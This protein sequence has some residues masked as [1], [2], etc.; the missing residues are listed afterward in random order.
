MSQPKIG[1]SMLY[2]LSEPFSKMVKQLSSVPTK[3][4][5]V[6]DDGYHALSKKRVAVLNQAVKSHSLKYSVHAPFADINVASPSKTML[7]AS[8]K[9]L[10]L[11]MQYANDLDA[12]LWVFH[13]GYKS[14]IS[15]FYPGA[16][17]KQN[18]TSIQ[19]LDKTATDYGIKIAMENLPEKYNFLMK[20]P[21]DFTKFYTETGLTDI[22]IV[23]DTGHAYLEAQIQPFLQQ[24]PTKIAHVHISDNHGETD[25][26]LGLGSGSINWQQFTKELKTTG[27]SGTVLT[28]SVFNVNETL[29]KLKELFA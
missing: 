2:M 9:R 22:G 3:Y 19:E 15:S 12:Y 23:L 24:L 14:G 1:L 5:E 8:M 28:E 21:Q 4:I 10:K 16:D 7:K 13:P 27:F 25:E 17:W 20:T 29:Q 6:V 26:H 18:Q 11:S